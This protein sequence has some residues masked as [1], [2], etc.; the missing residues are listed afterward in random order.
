M[1]LLETAIRLLQGSAAVPP[2]NATA[3]YTSAMHRLGEGNLLAARTALQSLSV[4]AVTPAERSLV[5]EAEIW[6]LLCEG[7]KAAARDAAACVTT[8]SPLLLALL[9][10]V[11]GTSE[12]AIDALA[13]ALR[14]TPSTDLVTHALVACGASTHFAALLERPGIVTRINDMSLQGASAHVFH[15]GAFEACERICTMAFRAYG[16]PVH[17]FNAACCAARRGD[18]DA[19]IVHVKNA[20]AA[21]WTDRARLASDPDLASLRADARFAELL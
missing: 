8:S 19:G 11:V 17:L 16:S 5:D 21:G 2:P 1:G 7:K 15:A 12:G 18:I 10:V 3:L 6:C 20:L 9:G 14:A 13:D 4:I